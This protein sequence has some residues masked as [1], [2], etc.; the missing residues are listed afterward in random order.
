MYF[1]AVGLQISPK[2][3]RIK[4]NV[5]TKLVSFHTKRSDSSILWLEESK[6]EDSVIKGSP[7]HQKRSL[8]GY[9]SSAS[10]N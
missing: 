3:I 7:H 8:P 4:E 9:L 1:I 5:I 2:P 10:G 6:T